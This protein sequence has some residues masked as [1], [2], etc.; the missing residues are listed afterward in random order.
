MTTTSEVGIFLDRLP[1]PGNWDVYYLADKVEPYGPL[2]ALGRSIDEAFY[3][4]SE[5]T[6]MP[7]HVKVTSI[8]PTFCDEFEDVPET[9]DELRGLIVEA[10]FDAS[11][12]RDRNHVAGE[13]AGRLVASAR[14][15]PSRAFRRGRRPMVTAPTLRR[16][17]L[18]TEVVA[19]SGRTCA[20]VS[21]R[22]ERFK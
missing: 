14:P 7:A 10:L 19:R 4:F 16:S 20:D 12:Q 18:P 9:I 22:K 1:I 6:G 8:R 11:T 13:Q 17:A 21:L 3:R 15:F 2:E 5:L